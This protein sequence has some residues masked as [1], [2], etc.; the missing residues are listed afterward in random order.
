MFIDEIFTQAK[1]FILG[2]Q[3]RV[4]SRID[5]DDPRDI[6]IMRMSYP[7]LNLDNPDA[8]RTLAAHLNKVAA[9]QG[10][11]IESS[12]SDGSAPCLAF[13]LIDVDQLSGRCPQLQA[14]GL[15][16]VYETRPRKCRTVPLDESV[17][18]ELLGSSVSENIVR[19]VSAGGK[20]EFSDEAPVIWRDGLLTSDQ[21]RKVHGASGAGMTKIVGNIS[22][23]LV[24]E[25]LEFK[26]L[27]NESS[28][29]TF[30]NIVEYLGVEGKRPVLPLIPGLARLTMMGAIT[31]NEGASILLGQADLIEDRLPSIDPDAPIEGV[32][33][34]SMKV[35][36]SDWRDMYLVVADA[37]LSQG[38]D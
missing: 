24:H 30:A 31:R 8:R 19:M 17:P 10:V 16:G 11:G 29:N 20:C 27:E 35:V 34:A 1:N 32:F 23:A 14:D 12:I 33:G 21:D 15:C 38:N 7:E 37:W 9:T 2:A 6:T 26:A 22:K 25:Y 3:L 28:E 18:E 13:A 5:P 36:L 4:I